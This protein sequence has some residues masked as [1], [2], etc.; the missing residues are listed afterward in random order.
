MKK[1]Q[2]NSKKKKCYQCPTLKVVV[3]EKK[4]TM[5]KNLEKLLQRTRMEI[6]EEHG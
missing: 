6:L 5:N 1:L 3:N 4:K 2:V